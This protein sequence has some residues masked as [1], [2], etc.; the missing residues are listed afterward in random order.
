MKK[1][2]IFVF[3]LWMAMQKKKTCVIKIS[4]DRKLLENSIF[5]DWYTFTSTNTW[6]F[7]PNF[8]TRKIDSFQRYMYYMLISFSFWNIFRRH[9]NDLLR[10]K[11]STKIGISELFD[12]TSFFSHWRGVFSQGSCQRQV[13][14]LLR[15]FCHY[16]IPSTALWMHPYSLLFSHLFGRTMIYVNFFYLG[17]TI[18]I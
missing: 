18:S 16:W 5:A 6:P 11:C 9:L 8:F 13:E 10:K 3:S 15:M 4:K 17:Q 12:N 2:Q 1:T 7:F 14:E